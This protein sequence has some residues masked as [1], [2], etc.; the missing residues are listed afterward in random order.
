MLKSVQL[1]Q[2]ARELYSAETGN[3]SG[4][5]ALSL[6]PFGASLTPAQEFDGFYPPPYGPKEYSAGA[7]NVNAFDFKSDEGD[8]EQ[9]S[10]E[11]LAH[12]HYERLLIF[13]D[14][15]KAWETIDCIAFE[16]VPL[17]RE[18]TS[19]RLAMGQL[20]AEISRRGDV[21][22]DIKPWW[23]SAV[24]PNGRFP[25][26]HREDSSS[27]NIKD[28]V[29]SALG[30]QHNSDG[31]SLNLPV[32]SAFGINCT[33]IEHLPALLKEISEATTSQSTSSDANKPWLVVYPNGGE[34]Y[35]PISQTWL[36][37][38][39][40]ENRDAPWAQRLGHIVSDL[41]KN[42]AFAIWGGVIVGGCCRIGPKEIGMLRNLLKVSTRSKE[43]DEQK[44]ASEIQS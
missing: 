32:P 18:I 16:T 27:R 41:Y 22:K 7:D 19:I 26:K 24:F 20:A 30:R 28:V 2:D 14:D 44:R 21:N 3:T 10:I 8:K 36:P 43:G 12:F 15:A 37:N 23:I 1:A 11:A 5:I 17:T 13:L 40:E 4:R 34:T 39:V 9:K 38:N 25:E 33:A 42:A 35:D 29:H 6:G 31:P